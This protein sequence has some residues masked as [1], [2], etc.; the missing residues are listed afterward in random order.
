[1]PEPRNPEIADADEDPNVE[2]RP[3]SSPPCYAHEID[4]AYFGL[5]TP[6]DASRVDSLKRLLDD[7]ETAIAAIT[8]TLSR[9]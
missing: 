1:M 8:R 2:I 7:A 6:A 9:R 4:P 3:Y 5:P